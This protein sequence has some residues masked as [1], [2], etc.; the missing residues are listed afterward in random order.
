MKEEID[1]NTMEFC[2]FFPCSKRTISKFY[3]LY[4]SLSYLFIYLNWLK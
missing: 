4:I 2:L 1:F 3:D